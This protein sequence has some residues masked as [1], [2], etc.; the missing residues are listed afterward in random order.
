MIFVGVLFDL[1]PIL[2]VV[3]AVV[4]I[5]MLGGD[6]IGG[7]QHL[8][9]AQDTS[10]FWKS[11][12]NPFSGFYR[13]YHN[14]VGDAKIVGGVV[15]G[16]LVGI[17]LGP[18]I[19]TLGSWVSTFFAYIF[20]TIWFLFRGVFI[21]SF[22]SPSR[23]AITTTTLVIE[24]IPVVDLLPGT[25]FMVWRHIKKSRTEDD[26]KHNENIASLNAVAGRSIPRYMKAQTV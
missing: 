18:V 2:L 16:G 4:V 15:G 19:Y 11:T 1:T 7:A 3:L 5:V 20:F 22:T 9:Q 6:I 12:W 21:W 26:K 25:T 8:Q 14:I 23:L 13:A 24:N 17:F 10:G